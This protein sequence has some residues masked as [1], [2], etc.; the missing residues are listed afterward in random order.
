MSEFIDKELTC[1]L[2]GQIFVW[3]AGEQAYFH[4]KGLQDPRHCKPCRKIRRDAIV[5]GK[6]VP[7]PPE[8][9]D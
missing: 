4:T 3:S 7:L 9:G 5:E 2:C 1:K 8:E 6:S